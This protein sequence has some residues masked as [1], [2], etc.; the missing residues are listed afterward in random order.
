MLPETPNGSGFPLNEKI[1][2]H[3]NCI[4]IWLI[5][6][7]IIFYA[8]IQGLV[9]V[10]ALNQNSKGAGDYSIL[11]EN[12]YR[13]MDYEIWLKWAYY[14]SLQIFAEVSE[15]CCYTTLSN[16]LELQT[17][18]CR[19]ANTRRFFYKSPKAVNNWFP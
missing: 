7:Y 6:S 8:N 4:F 15:I 18:F 14:T 5:G 10:G 17:G 1:F 9:P 2:L 13:R 12:V 11:N 16:K 19:F 3:I